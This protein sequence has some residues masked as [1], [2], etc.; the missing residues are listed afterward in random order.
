MKTDPLPRRWLAAAVLL[1]GGAL[2]AAS[3]NEA[4]IRRA[5]AERLPNLPPIDEV[6]RT[7]MPGLWEVRIGTDLLYTDERGDFVVQGSLVDTR[8]R[9]NLTEQRVARLTAID[10]AALPLTDAMV[11]R[12]GSGAR[13]IAVFGD[14]NCS[15]C[16]RFERDLMALRDVTIYMFLYPILGPDSTATSRAIW[17]APDPMR[18]WRALMVEGSAPPRLIGRCDDGAL[19]RNVALGQRHRINGTPAVVFEDGTRRQGALGAAELERLL[20]AHS[21]PAARR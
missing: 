2:L 6:T 16:R 12:Q 13:R 10:F 21:R 20:A 19:A 14:P 9:S 5:L 15:F 11:V 18:A 17:C 1:L 8:T 4:Q 3:A 7:P